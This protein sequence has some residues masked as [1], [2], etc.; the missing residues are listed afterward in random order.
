MF[1]DLGEKEDSDHFATVNFG[2]D[3]RCL[4]ALGLTVALPFGFTYSAFLIGIRGIWIRNE[5][6]ILGFYCSS[7]L[8]NIIVTGT[9][10]YRLNHLARFVVGRLASGYKVVFALIIESGIAYS[11]I[12]LLVL[13]SFIPLMIKDT[14]SWEDIHNGFVYVLVLASGITPTL[15][16]V[17]VAMGTSISDIRNSVLPTQDRE[18]GQDL[19]IPGLQSA[20]LCGA[21]ISSWLSSEVILNIDVFASELSTMSE[22]HDTARSIDFWRK[23]EDPTQEP[24]PLHSIPLHPSRSLLTTFLTA[25]RS[26]F[27][28]SIS[29][30]FSRVQAGSSRREED[31][32]RKIA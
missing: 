4:T 24:T 13:C 20:G 29:C 25:P 15:L 7:F 26:P 12:I 8:T 28:H 3:F 14:L 6:L 23:K 17:R 10:A 27:A 30:V 32:Y 5:P 22:F 2:R 9:M 11:F 1:Y 19:E 31:S 16:L 21:R 18:A